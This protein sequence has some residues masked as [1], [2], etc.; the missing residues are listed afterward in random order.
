MGELFIL[1][2]CAVLKFN[3]AHTTVGGEVNAAGKSYPHRPGHITDGGS[4]RKIAPK[5]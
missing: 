5:G 1:L 3:L 4:D 2:I